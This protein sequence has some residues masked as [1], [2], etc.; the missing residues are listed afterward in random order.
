M[1]G[2]VKNATILRIR[3]FC[4]TPIAKALVHT[5]RGEPPNEAKTWHTLSR[6]VLDVLELQIGLTLV[7]LNL[8]YCVGA[9][10]CVWGRGGGVLTSV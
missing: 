5:L 3:T 4:M 9:W 8:I 7:I 2:L 6:I 10:L 1:G